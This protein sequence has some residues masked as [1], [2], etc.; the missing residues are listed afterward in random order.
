MRHICY[1]CICARCVEQCVVG[2]SREVCRTDHV[3]DEKGMLC[4]R[5]WGA[6]GFLM[7]MSWVHWKEVGRLWFNER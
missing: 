6:Y 4:G 7:G 3:A 2:I 5:D 1:T